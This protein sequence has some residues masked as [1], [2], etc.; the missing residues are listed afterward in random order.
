MS[1]SDL[2]HIEVCAQK[3]PVVEEATRLLALEIAERCGA[4]T[5]SAPTKVSLELS[6]GIGREGFCIE[7]AGPAHIRISGNDERGLL[8]GVGKFL[9]TSLMGDGQFVPST[10]RGTSVPDKELR[11]IYLATHFFN[12]YHVA[13]I[14]DIERYMSEL[15]L[16][17]CNALM[18]VFDIKLFQS[19]NDPE[20]REIAERL[21]AVLAAGKR[22]GM[23]PA[24]TICANAGYAGSPKEL[25]AEAAGIRYGRKI[26]D[27]CPSKP[28]AR[29]LL[30][31]AFDERLQAFG[32]VG[33]DI[34]T[35]WPYDDGGCSCEKCSPWGSNGFL[36]ISEPMSRRFHQLN[37]GG[38]VILSTWAFDSWADDN[39]K[40]LVEWEGLKQ[41][42]AEKSDWVD[43]V[44]TTE[45]IV[46]DPKL[47]PSRRYKLDE[48]AP[49]GRPLVDFP[50]ISMYG[51]DPWGVFGANPFPTHLETQWHKIS[52][53]IAG[54]IAYSEGIYED[55]N[56]VLTLQFYW[57]Q[58]ADPMEVVHDYAAYEYAAEA[59]ADVV[60][61]V[62][63]LE[64]NHQHLLMCVTGGEEQFHENVIKAGAPDRPY[65]FR[66]KTGA[67]SRAEECLDILEAVDRALSQRARTSWRWRLLLVRARLDVEL[68]RNDTLPNPNCEPFFRELRTLYCA[69]EKT[70]DRHLY[71]PLADTL[72][73]M[74]NQ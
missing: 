1:I 10:W 63:I 69:Q 13:P 51:M 73:R 43:Y 70:E 46:K 25:W 67:L 8:Y 18:V 22:V 28:R 5:V 66:V 26:W 58:D 42:L 17:G 38:T 19:I 56:K 31:E 20:A 62:E 45:R 59:A 7:D 64:E 71:F 6:D 33:I 48:G 29:E 72:E 2:I 36:K 52:E 24:L 9:H 37:P 65:E 15:A 49:G 44:M 34:V 11:G 35:L 16:W 74:F 27:L 68:K 60:R 55:F 39:G 21:N 14:E 32:D 4:S 53:H 54:G 47:D 12:W 41:A 50:E 57:S 23:R 40:A 30:L 61:A 3:T